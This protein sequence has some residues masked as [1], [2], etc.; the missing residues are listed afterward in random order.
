MARINR[1][2]R[3][4]TFNQDA[5]LALLRGV[6]MLADAV[7]VTLGP[8]GRYVVLAK[9]YNQP[10][11][12]TKD[13]VS[14]ARQ[15]VLKNLEENAGNRLVRRAAIKTS[16]LAGDGT[17]TAVVLAQQIFNA[18]L[19]NIVWGANA[20]AIKRGI[21][22]AVGVTVGEMSRMSM[23]AKERDQLS[24]VAAIAANNDGA[25]GDIVAEAITAVGEEG[26]ILVEEGKGLSTSLEV[27]EGMQ[28]NRGYLSRHFITDAKN[29]ECVL[30]EPNI[31]I[32]YP[33][34]DNLINLVPALEL[35]IK[36]KKPFLIMAEFIEDSIWQALVVNKVHHGLECAAVN[37]PELYERGRV[38]LEDIAIFTGANLVSPDKGLKLEN[39][40]VGDLGSAK[41]VIIG[42]GKTTIVGGGG[43][44]S[45]IEERIERLK[46]E[47]GN[48]KGIP[49]QKIK[50][51]LARLASG[52]AVIHVGGA[53]EAEI[54][55][56]KDGVENALNAARASMKEGILP[57]GGTALIRSIPALEKIRPEDGDEQTGVNIVKK[58]LEEP[59]CQLAKNGGYD[60]R[61]V[62]EK[63]KAAD[64]NIGFNVQTGTYEDMFS[65]GIT[66]PAKVTRIAL[67]TAASVSSLLLTT[68]A[69][70][71]IIPGKGELK[72]MFQ[73]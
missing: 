3:R 70:V 14:V 63:V 15:I 5:R 28:F 20:V 12:F 72:K 18:G 25:I 17:T 71:T 41:K 33:R 19:K 23:P 37:A 51:R 54:R 40:T 30:E 31:L 61:W 56:K 64:G 73:R 32:Y 6:N 60:G 47:A 2:K 11:A 27:K 36:Q 34:L 50:E 24:R 29:M 4:L 48:S 58:A 59:L 22:K 69:L 43:K 26:V 16:K 39:V 9:G 8:K 52:V 38:V 62:V 67:E 7:K 45:E 42:T 49:R 68:E 10:L 1:E 66:D 57:G 55:E 13:G 65:A 46:T 44:K 53:T 21:E 35:L